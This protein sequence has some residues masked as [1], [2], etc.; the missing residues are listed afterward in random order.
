M[1]R[2]HTMTKKEL[3]TNF[4]NNL[5]IE[6]TKLHL[7]QSEM[8]DKLDLSLS[9]YKRIISGENSKINL[10]IAYNLYNLTGKMAFEFCNQTNPYLSLISK[11]HSLT[12]SQLQVIN[13]IIDFQLDCNRQAGSNSSQDLITVFIPTGNME[14]GMILDSANYEKLDVSPY[15]S[16]FGDALT[17]G[18]KITS[19]HLHPVYHLNDILLLSCSPIRDGDTGIFIN[20]NSNRAYIRKFHQTSPTILE[21]INGYGATFTVD[22][23]NEK[24]MTQWIKF[25]HVLSKIH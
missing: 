23:H 13:S 20:T 2:G 10:N 22:S 25:G 4:A 17:C 16:K 1:Q 15:R 3:T 11:I 24:D 18:I 21:P 12:P 7:S 8:A 5:E 9:S 6:R 14:D 19:N